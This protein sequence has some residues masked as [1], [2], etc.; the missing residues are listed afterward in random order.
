MTNVLITKAGKIVECFSGSTHEATCLR[1]L[2]V[3]LQDFLCKHGGIRVMAGCIDVE[4][5][6]VEY[7]FKPT[8]IQ[9][10]IL[11]KILRKDN[12]YTVLLGLGIITK[13][14]PIRSFDFNQYVR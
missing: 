7:Y 12:Y 9:I 13:F 10:R 2:H 8:A 5:V 3:K 4:T 11:H 1:E 6:A 14:R